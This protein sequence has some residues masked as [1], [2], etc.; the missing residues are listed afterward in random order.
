MAN[1]PRDLAHC[2]TLLIDLTQVERL[3]ILD[4]RRGEY[5]QKW[6]LRYKTSDISEMKQ[7]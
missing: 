2:T 3:Q 7:S 6:H 5:I 4:E 1:Y